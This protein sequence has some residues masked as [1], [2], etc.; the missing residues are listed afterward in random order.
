MPISLPPISR[1]RFLAGSL[2]AG[3]GMILA[4]PAWTAGRPIDEHSWAL[5]SDSHLAA[6]PDTVSRD[7]NMAANFKAVVRE[8]CGLERPPAAVL[9]NGDLAFNTGESGDYA[10]V[11]EMLQPLRE[12]GLPVHLTLGNHDERA[13][14]WE[15]LPD[16]KAEKRPVVDRQSALLPSSRVNWFVLDSLEKVNSTPGFLG[17]A[18][19]D[20]LNRALKENAGK[21]AIIV[22]HHNP[23]VMGDPKNGLQDS[24]QLMAILRPLQ[25]VKALIFGHT[26]DWGVQQDVSGIQL[27]NLPPTSYVFTRGRPSGWVLAGLREQGMRLEFHCLDPKHAA[28]GQVV[29]LKWR[30]A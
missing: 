18:Q 29:D 1:R 10:L 21:P 20:W 22:C 6:N 23:Q 17:E 8:V 13:R 19:R 16:A 3:A 9:V 25:H 4:P 26:H 27:V 15:V 30:A 12:A 2:A 7:V 24:E 5:L 14:F 28:N 11:K